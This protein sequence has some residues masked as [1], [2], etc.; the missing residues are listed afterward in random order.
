MKD[1]RIEE[2]IDWAREKAKACPKLKDQINDYVQLA[3]DEIEEGASISHE[4][5][6]C[7]SDIEELIN[8][9]CN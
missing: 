8:E 6:L 9:N 2:L 7:M 5:Q 3:I 4:I 1:K